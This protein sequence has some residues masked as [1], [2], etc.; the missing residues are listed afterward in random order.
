MKRLLLTCLSLTFAFVV[1]AQERSVSG[2]ITGS[3]DG[4]VLPGVNILIQGTTTGT[5]TDSDG[6][7]KLNVPSEGAT[8]VFSFVGYENSVIETGN[9]STIDLAMIPDISQLQEVVV[10]AFGIEK[11]KKALPYS[12]TE[13]QGEGFTEAREINIADAIAG[14]VAGVNVSNIGSGVGGSSRVII[15]G[16]TSIAGNNQPLYVID[17]VPIDNTQ[18][19]SAGMWGGSD[20]GDGTSSINPDDIESMTVLKGNTAAALYGSRASNGVILIT[21]K[22]GTKRKGIGVE[23]NS[24]FTADQINNLFDFQTEYGHGS[25]GAKPTTDLEA[26]QFGASSWGGKLDGSSV[27]QFD[28]QSRP[29]SYQGDNFEKYYRTG[30]TITNTVALTGGGD[31]QTFRFSASD[32][33]N[34]SVTPNSG[35]DRQ[36]FSL[37]TNANWVEKLTLTAK[38]QYSRENVENRSRLSDAP[39]NGNYTLSVLPPS[40][41]VEDLRGPTDKLGA[42]EDGTELPY[43]GSIFTQN[44]YWAAHQFVTDDR[45]DR[46]IGS[47]LLKYEFTDWLYLQGRIGMDWYTNRRTG[48]TP[49]GTGYSARGQINER[50]RR[51]SETNLEFI[52]G[53]DKTF[54]NI[55][56]NGFVGGNRMRRSDETLGA[57]G[58]NFNIPFFHTISN[59]ANQ[60]VVYA[61]SEKGINS[62]F[63]SVEFSY[64]NF[65]FLSATGRND[66]FSTLNPESNNIFYPSVGTSFV[67]S[68]AFDAPDWLTFGKIRASWAEVGGDTNPYQTGLTYSLTGQGHLGAALG[69]ITQGSIPNPNLQPL[70]VSEIEV[71]FDIRLFNNRIGIDYAYYSRKTLDDILQASVS[72]ST[73]YGSATVNVG[74]I[75]NKGHELLISATPVNGPLRWDVTFNFAHNDTEVTKLVGDQKVFQA[76]E[77]RSRNAFAQHRIEYTDESGV[78]QPGGYSVIV[79]RTHKMINGQKVYTAEGLPV[80]SDDLAVLGSGVHPNTLGFTNSFTYKNFSLSFLLDMKFGGDLYVGT[81]ATAVGSGNHKITLEGRESGISV[82][83]VDEEGNPLSVTIPGSDVQDYWGRYNDIAEYFV[84]DAD[85]IKLRQLTLGYNLPNS[86]LSKTPFS[87]ARISIVGR[88]LWLIHSNIENVDP[89]QTYNTSNGQG[90]EW[91]GVPQAQSYGFNVNLKF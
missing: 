18:L 28:G 76:Q 26:L 7:Y 43:T 6:N 58:S 87:G 32:L 37:S 24:N 35:M 10:T 21:T 73:G 15:R 88:N 12:V 74:E 46:M 36:N 30:T 49:F 84:E 50:E 67:F 2:K 78:F 16:N 85:F 31:R 25:R 45:R 82:S 3:D 41:N 14:K 23:I 81:N 48:I 40:I 63:G 9:R 22:K 5:T 39:G 56:V 90:L 89:E 61:F 42:R 4:A 1:A 19:G 17:G 44:P 79:G 54:G 55:R 38:I 64:K 60:S 51:V 68:D 8:L 33:R 83:G 52:L 69:R 70:S 77:A 27:M 57:N 34:E 13:L 66:W 29:Y 72:Q 80:Q 86:I 53:A 71:G 91:F 47:G 20:F 11:E 75:S 59:A 62:L 65:I